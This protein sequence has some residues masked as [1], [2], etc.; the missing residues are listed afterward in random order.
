MLARRADFAS[1]YRLGGGP[2]TGPAH[3][4]PEGFTRADA[5]TP[6]GNLLDILDRGVERPEERALLGALLALSLET[7]PPESG[8]PAAEVG[9]RL[10]WL[11]ANTPCDALSALDSVLG[12]APEIWEGV[13]R[14][15]RAPELTPEDFGATEE[16][17]AAAAL[18]RSSSPDAQALRLE[19]ATVV[20]DPALYALL[21][22][23]PGELTGALTGELQP[24]PRGPVLTA[25]LALTLLLFLMNAGRFIGRHAL[26]Y[27][28]PAAVRLGPQGLEL[29]QRIEVMNQ[30][31]RDRATLVPLSNIARVTR[32]VKYARIGLYAGLMA[33]TLGTYFGTGLFV[34][35]VR[36]PGGSAPLLGL[37]A[38]FVI[39]GLGADFVLNT[40]ADSA[41]GRCR[42]IVVPRKGK[43]LCVG[44]LDP[45]QADALLQ[46]V[47][48]QNRSVEPEEPLPVA[49]EQTTAAPG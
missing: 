48:E 29:T 41:R 23:G 8:E 49:P 15:I 2:A 33:L 28:R 40:G 11:A 4:P 39:V 12:P 7:D 26:R 25:V 14:V 35:G 27:R 10:V 31:L 20:Q 24:P 5:E 47:A 30:V 6:Y 18:R 38:L 19:A 43:T 16:L 45:Q 9:L 36:V 1:R 46:A 44:G 42:L 13:A 37:A 17:V 34:D 32:E 22:L 3:L 21:A